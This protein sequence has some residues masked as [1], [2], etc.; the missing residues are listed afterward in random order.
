MEAKKLLEEG[1]TPVEVY[2]STKANLRSTVESDAV[3][4]AQMQDCIAQYTEALQQVERALPQISSDQ[5]A[6]LQALIPAYRDRVQSLR[7][8][9]AAVTTPPPPLP[10]INAVEDDAVKL[11]YV[12]G[13]VEDAK[14]RTSN[15]ADNAL[16]KLNSRKNQPPP[17]A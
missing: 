14:N 4:E 2:I 12:K 9:L 10:L 5:Q 7:A 13:K 11:L 17:T 8:A 3:S 6:E 16:A 1:G 15:I